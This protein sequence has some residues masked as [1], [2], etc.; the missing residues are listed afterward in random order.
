MSVLA[1]CV[2]VCVGFVCVRWLCVCVLAL[3]VCVCLGFSCL[4][5]CVF[6]LSV[7]VLSLTE[8]RAKQRVHWRAAQRAHTCFFCALLGAC[9]V[10]DCTLLD[11]VFSLSARNSVGVNCSWRIVFLFSTTSPASVFL[12]ER[13]RV[14][15]GNQQRHITQ[16]CRLGKLHLQGDVSMGRPLLLSKVSAW[17]RA[18]LPREPLTLL[19][20]STVR[21]ALWTITLCAGGPHRGREREL[22]VPLDSFSTELCVWWATQG[23]REN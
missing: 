9:F 19:A 21:F 8:W 17:G 5:L 6:W 15:Q 1:L 2:C 13:E 23:S 11:C 22:N 18:A 14:T 20:L 4:A 7:R 10:L 12:R 16:D 3:C